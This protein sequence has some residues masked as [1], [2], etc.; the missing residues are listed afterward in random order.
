MLQMH[1]ETKLQELVLTVQSA[2]AGHV[3]PMR[4]FVCVCVCSQET[5]TKFSYACVTSLDRVFCIRAV[6]YLCHSVGD[7]ETVLTGSQAKNEG[8]TTPVLFDRKSM[9]PCAT[10]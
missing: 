3:A 10:Y 8:T 4:P 5:D 1:S 6:V 9:E 2:T 7:H